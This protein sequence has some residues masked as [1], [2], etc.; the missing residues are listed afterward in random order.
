MSLINTVQILRGYFCCIAGTESVLWAASSPRGGAAE[1]RGI[2]GNKM[3]I[4]GYCLVLRVY[5]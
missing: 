2:S 5:W 4:P 1:N 3:E